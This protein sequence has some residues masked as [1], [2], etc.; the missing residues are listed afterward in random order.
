M[1]PLYEAAAQLE[2]TLGVIRDQRADAIG[3]RT[4]A[5]IT[6]RDGERTLDGFLI[7]SEPAILYRA[8]APGAP[9]KGPTPFLLVRVLAGLTTAWVRTIWSWSRG[10]EKIWLEPNGAFTAVE[11]CDGSHDRLRH[12]RQGYSIERV[13]RGETRRTLLTGLTTHEPVVSQRK[14]NVSPPIFAEVLFGS[15]IVFDLGGDEYRRSEETWQEAGHPTAHVRIV[16]TPNEL[17]LDITVHKSGAFTFVPKN[18][19]NPYDNEHPDIN[20]DGVQLYLADARGSSSWMLVPDVNGAEAGKLRIRV[21]DGWE[22]LRKHASWHPVE[23]GYA[24]SVRLPVVLPRGPGAHIGLGIVVNEMPVG[25]ER[26]RGQLVLGGARGEFVYLRGDREDL[27][28][29]PRVRIAR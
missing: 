29:L 20:G 9:G 22:L 4:I 15:P 6:A 25:R 27:D 23:G 21:I 12:V 7:T 24:L 5:R 10:V 3:A 26:R 28:R 13:V 19:V 14:S 2:D 16:C 17:T 18:A 11:R 8:T 1:F